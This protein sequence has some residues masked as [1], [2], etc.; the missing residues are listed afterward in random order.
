MVQGI[1]RHMGVVLMITGSL[2]T[3]I[4]FLIYAQELQLMVANG[5]WNTVGDKT[6]ATAAFWFMVTG[7]L[8]I[9]LGHT[10]DW[11]MKKQGIAPPVTFGWT[12]LLVCL[13][14]AIA[15][16]VSGFWLVLPQAWILLRK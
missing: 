14:G 12:L 13:A 9:L 16:P 6:V 2:H 15:M 7:F 4:G 10:A 5:W 8:L 11:L 1:K 3:A